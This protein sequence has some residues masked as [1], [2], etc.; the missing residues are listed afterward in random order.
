MPESRS[1]F[2]SKP[3]LS[4]ESHPLEPLVDAMID[5]SHRRG[6][7]PVLVTPTP[8]ILQPALFCELSLALL[9]RLEQPIRFDWFREVTVGLPILNELW[10]S[11]WAKK[12]NRKL[13][14]LTDASPGQPTLQI[15]PM[16]ARPG[17]SHRNFVI[18]W[19]DEQQTLPTWAAAIHLGG[20]SDEQQVSDQQ[21]HREQKVELMPLPKAA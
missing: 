10:A 12:I 17:G 1:A 5:L 18:G 15:T 20:Q 8:I 21:K 4:V 6:V 2:I 11:L 16:L 19:S 7:T 3:H 14:R 13:R 9:P